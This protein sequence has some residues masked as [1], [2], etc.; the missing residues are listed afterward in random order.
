[1]SG[2]FIDE[3]GTYPQGFWIRSPHLSV[4]FPYV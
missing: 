2:T 4:H 1:L 3:H